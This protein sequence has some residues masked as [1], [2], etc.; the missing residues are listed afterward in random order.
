MGDAMT[1]SRSAAGRALPALLV[2]V[3]A[4]LLGMYSS[5]V[6]GETCKLYALPEPEADGY[7]LWMAADSVRLLAS[8]CC[9]TL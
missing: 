5:D 6:S 3:T 2:L 9:P 7:G 1:A 4:V 8:C